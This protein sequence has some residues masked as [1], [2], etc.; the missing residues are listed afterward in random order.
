MTSDCP[1]GDACWCLR[2]IPKLEDRAEAE[3]AADDEEASAVGAPSGSGSD[4]SPN[5]P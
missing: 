4:G 3:P 5:V 2:V 1:R